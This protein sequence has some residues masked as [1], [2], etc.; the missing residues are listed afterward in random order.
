VLVCIAV[1]PGIIPRLS[2]LVARIETNKN[3]PAAIE[4][5]VDHGDGA[6][7]VLLTMNTEPNTPDDS[8]LPSAGTSAAWKYKAIYHYQDAQ[9]GQWGDV[10]SVT[11]GNQLKRA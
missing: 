7:F 6:N 8:P 9:V 2:S 11:V 4:I 3:Y 10:I 5:W 1:L